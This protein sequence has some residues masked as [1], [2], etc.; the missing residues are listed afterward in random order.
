MA[1]VVVDNVSIAIA[2][3]FQ[4]K[5]G[6]RAGLVPK[7]QLRVLQPDSSSTSTTSSIQPLETDAKTTPLP[8]V[9]VLVVFKSFANACSYNMQT[10]KLPKN[11]I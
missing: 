6:D 1:H 5:L 10:F 3:L 2:V 4:V 7:S 9:L 8:V 11:F